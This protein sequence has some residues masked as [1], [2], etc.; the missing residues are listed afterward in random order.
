MHAYALER[1]TLTQL[2]VRADRSIQWVRNN[3]YAAPPVSI[4]VTPQPTVIIADTTFWGRSYGIT[5]FRSPSLK[6]NLWWT[7]V[8]SERV[9]TYAQ[10]RKYLE[11]HG[12]TITAVVVDGRRGLTRVFDD[13]P[14]QICI[15][16]QM[17]R[18]TTYLTRRPE[19]QAGQELRAI[20]LCLPKTTEDAFA[21]LLAHWHD[22]WGSFIAERTHIPGTNRWYYTHKNV[23]GAYT[24][25]KRNFSYLFTHERF[26]ERTIP[27]TTNSLDGMFTQ[28]KNKLAVHRGLHGTRRYRII[29]EILS[30]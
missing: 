12:W 21:A 2:A 10:G 15:F 26:P 25:L 27:T 19:T 29:S 5:V 23:R 18:V 24:S 4:A 17:K 6:K 7:E 9:A 22:A 14:V 11:T 28:L 30:Q 8:T 16:H 13:I 1:Q 3:L 20:M